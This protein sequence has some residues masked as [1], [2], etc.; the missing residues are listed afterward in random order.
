MKQ[1]TFSDLEL[2]KTRSR[3]TRSERQLEKINRIVDWQQVEQLLSKTDKTGKQGGRRPIPV[4]VKAKMLF[5]QYLYNLSDPELEDQLHDRLS[6]QRFVGLDF[7]DRIPDFTTLWRF[8][9]RLAELG[10]MDAL[11]ELI[12]GFLEEKGLLVKKGTSVDATIVESINRPLSKRKRAELEESPSSQ[13]DTDADSTRKRGKDYFGYK[14]HIGQDVGSGLIRKR[15]FTSARPHDSQ[16]KQVL[17]SGDEQAV[18][19]DSA[20]SNMADKRAARQLGVH[21][22]I[23]DKGT[24]KRKLSGSQKKKN[25]KHSSI[26]CKVE[27]PFAYMKEKLGYKVAGAKNQLR[28][29]LRFDMNCILY[30]IMRA[31]VLL[32]RTA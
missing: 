6:F 30:N 26:R 23:L 10:L 21:Y 3:K 4:V 17:F 11:F 8:K 27:H 29:S 15:E 9:E 28:N 24:R 16:Y 13:I 31:D 25:K 19:G 22:G 1:L 20:Y 14:G 12:V 2:R 32:A 18:F 5:V 7:S